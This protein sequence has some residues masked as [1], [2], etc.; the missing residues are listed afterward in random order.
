MNKKNQEPLP[1]TPRLALEISSTDDRLRHDVD[2]AYAVAKAMDGFLGVKGA[3]RVV[4]RANS[5]TKNTQEDHSREGTPHSNTSENE[6]DLDSP[7]TIDAVKKELDLLITYLRRVHMMCY[8][9]GL[10]CDSK[11]DLDRKCMEPHC[12]K[13]S[14]KKN[15]QEVSAAPTNEKGGNVIEIG[16]SFSIDSSHVNPIE[17]AWAKNLD[18]KLSL[19]YEK[20]RNRTLE[21]LG[22]KILKE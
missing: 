16:P 13:S 2:Q 1:R 22:G 12:R 7:S 17:L 6:D 21:R 10:E 5:I 8:Y 3:R 15:Q 4:D 19:K 14:E 18:S 11:E 20:P 9:C